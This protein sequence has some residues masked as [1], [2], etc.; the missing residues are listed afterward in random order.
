MKC[1]SIQ[2]IPAMAALA[3]LAVSAAAGQPER[4][5][6]TW[7]GD[8]A[9]SQ[10]VTW[11]SDLPA[12][13]AARAEITP[14]G[15]GPNFVKGARALVPATEEVETTPGGKR[16]QYH[17]AEFTGLEPDTLYAYRV[18][19]E[20]TSGGWNQFRTAKA[21]PAPLRFIYLGDAQN[22]IFAHWSRVVR[23]A[24]RDA[25]RA[26]FILHAGDLIN[27]ANHD[28]EWAEWFAAG[29]WA[30]EVIPCIATPGNHEYNTRRQDDG[31]TRSQL[32]D[33]WKPQFAFPRNGPDGLEDTVYYI[34]IQGVRVVSLNTNDK[35]EEQAKWLEGV[36]AD[37]PSR[38]TV[39]TFH[40]PV[41]STAKNRDNAPIRAAWQ[42]VLERHD[43][44]LVL[45]G[46][47]HA[48]GRTP[49]MQA[50]VVTGDGRAGTVYA[51]SVSGPKMYQL[52]PETRELMAR[53]AEDTQFYQV[54][55]IDGDTL[56]YEARTADEQLYDRFRVVKGSDGKKEFHDEAPDT[57]EFLR[58]PA[59]AKPAAN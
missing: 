12:D 14:A 30:N 38:W 55:S 33:F 2:L 53:R 59:K 42:P 51:L 37:N 20:M 43:V 29:G 5:I 52:S 26:H 54:I 46:H 56:T 24:F 3:A 57:A 41:Y 48:Y 36:L 19:D 28:S 1:R 49:K 6:L 17:T 45:Q 58:P 31:S 15:P 7:T 32:S 22:H 40:H 25:P 11:R 50:G 10:A 35:V 44:D 39:V 18:G 23:T 47:D 13:G 9:R 16:V 21:G 8:P 27:R 34:D 4:I